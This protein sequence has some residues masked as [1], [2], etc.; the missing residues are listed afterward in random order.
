MIKFAL[1][2]ITNP[3]TNKTKEIIV[4]TLMPNNPKQILIGGGLILAGVVYL[5]SSS[6]KKEKEIVM[7]KQKLTMETKLYFENGEEAGTF[8]DFVSDI[9]EMVMEE[10]GI[11]GNGF[12]APEKEE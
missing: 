7:E 6:F 5:T 3:K 12:D 4:K 10:L 8:A 2:D 11:K 1:C 9:T